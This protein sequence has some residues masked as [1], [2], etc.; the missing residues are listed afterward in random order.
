MRNLLLLATLLGL[1]ACRV[2][3]GTD[4]SLGETFTLK[5]TVRNA[6][7]GR[8]PSSLTAKLGDRVLATGTIDGTRFEIAVP[9]LGPMP[10]DAWPAGGPFAGDLECGGPSADDPVQRVARLTLQAQVSSPGAPAFDARTS[11]GARI[12]FS[13]RD[14][15]IHGSGSCEQ[16]RDHYSWN[17]DLLLKKGWNAVYADVLHDWNDIS[18]RYHSADEYTGPLPDPPVL[19]LD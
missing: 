6:V 19:T 14:G 1:G 17:F 4:G 11:I 13:D 7:T 16:G 9:A 2:V 12:L 15:R 3:T 10:D 8:E 18:P 5:G